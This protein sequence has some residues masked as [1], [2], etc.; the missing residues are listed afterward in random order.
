M[1]TIGE[2]ADH[3]RAAIRQGAHQGHHCHWPGCTK[4]CAPA[5]WGCTQHWYKLPAE[6]R[7]KIWTAYRPGQEES[8]TPS[9]KYME[10]AREVQDWIMT[11]HPPK[12]SRTL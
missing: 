11:N 1:T 4:T 6:L 3:V 2:K 9:A 5:Q 12:R 10:V 7:A 8:K